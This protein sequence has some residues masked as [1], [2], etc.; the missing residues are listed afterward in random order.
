MEMTAVTA[1]DLVARVA[2]G[3]L[4]PCPAVAAQV[5]AAAGGTVDASGTLAEIATIA[6]AMTRVAARVTVAGRWPGGDR[7][8]VLTE[9]DRVVDG[10]TAV[11]AAVL[12]AERDAGTWRGSGDRSFE[13]SRARS[14]RVGQRV[15]TAQVRQAAQ[16]AA[17]PEAVAAVVEGLISVEHAAVIGA[18]A[19]TGTPAQRAAVASEEGRRDLMALAQDV[20]AGTF[21]TSVARWVAT[22]NPAGSEV[23]HE[24]QR[25]ERYLQ[26]ATT[27]RGTFIK[28]RMDSMAG[29][30]LTRALEALSPRP[31]AEDD[32]S[33]G[34]RHADALEAMA[35]RI[36][37]A[38]DTKPGG[39]VPP[40]V[41]MILTAE[42]WVAGRAE[43]DRR[44]HAGSASVG[45]DGVPGYEP[46]TLEDGTP[47][48]ASVLAAAMC[49]CEITRVVID[50]EG[51]PLD[52]GRSQ[53]VFTGAQR[54]AVI[55]R[56]REC[57]W[58]GCDSHARW[59]DVHH[60]RWWERDEGPTSVENGVL[61]CSF[62]HHEV[63]RRDLAIARVSLPTGGHPPRPSPHR[64]V[65]LVAYEFRDRAGR[66]VGRASAPDHAAPD[67]S[68]TDPSAPN[69]SATDPS[70][71]ESSAPESPHGDRRG[72]PPVADM[73][74]VSRAD[75]PPL[76]WT[77]DP[78]TGVRVPTHFLDP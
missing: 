7:R 17:V 73:R 48:P 46:A 58:P 68:A 60:I 14:G 75:Q 41:T 54:R 56:D 29:H 25:A 5:S 35:G 71:P 16:L 39:H 51:V 57:A 59:D 26:V 65:A 22:V 44:R 4:P 49:D 70:A 63:H 27:P 20:D 62:H 33:P 2:G 13:A 23:G 50:A 21:A 34:Q 15:A 72:G 64:T 11:R 45:T 24:A 77:T 47:V 19:S 53:R 1:L 42:T 74:A 61:L 69:P 8:R 78:M 66:L 40:Q 43:R 67:L 32:R 28:G 18:V 55:A 76:E 37:A 30:K 3:S 52:V 9:L 6:A 31:G 36:L 10:L 12:V 38:P